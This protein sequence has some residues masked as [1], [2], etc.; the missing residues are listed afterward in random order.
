MELANEQQVQR[1][2]VSI[3]AAFRKLPKEIAK[4]RMRSAIRRATK[5]FE[6]MLRANT[7][8]FTGSLQR[9][10]KTKIRVYDKPTHGAAV[11]VIGYVRGTL[12]K[13]RG[14]FVIS[15]SGSHAILVERGTKPRNKRGTKAFC[16]SMPANYMARRTLDAMKGQIMNAV[17]VELA[18]ALEKTAQ[19]LAK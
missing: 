9:S 4:T 1:Q 7:P 2:I 12:R 10:L 18:T 11:A 13:K 3:I 15:G 6:P 5:P 17:K 8:H 16:G 19:E 14:Q